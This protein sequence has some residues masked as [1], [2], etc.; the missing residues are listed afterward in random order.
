MLSLYLVLSRTLWINVNTTKLAGARSSPLF[1]TRMTFCLQQ[2]L[3]FLH[4]VQKFLCQ[5]FGMKDK[6]GASYVIATKIY[7]E[8][9]QCT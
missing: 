1:C 2:D 7:K 3:N 8:R 5:H 4:E 9:S 6:V